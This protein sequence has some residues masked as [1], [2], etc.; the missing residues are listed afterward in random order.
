ML[1]LYLKLVL[2][3]EIETSITMLVLFLIVGLG[4][5]GDLLVVE[6]GKLLLF[7]GAP[8][9]DKENKWG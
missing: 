6:M 3:S 9:N 5:S 4:F 2:V 7:L 8:T 1:G